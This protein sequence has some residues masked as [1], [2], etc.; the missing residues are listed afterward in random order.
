M[1]FFIRGLES[2]S[3]PDSFP[4]LKTESS[5]RAQRLVSGGVR[6]TDQGSEPLHQIRDSNAERVRERLECLQRYVRFTSLNL[7]DV[8]PMQTGAVGQYILRPA[9]L[10]P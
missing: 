6:L 9:A 8:C 3:C 7:A 4:F 5:G 10:H 2:K 1:Q